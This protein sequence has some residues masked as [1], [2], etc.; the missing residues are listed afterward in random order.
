MSRRPRAGCTPRERVVET[1]VTEAARQLR[2]AGLETPLLAVVG[3]VVT[4]RAWLGAS[5]PH[6]HGASCAPGAGARGDARASG[7]GERG[8]SL[9]ISVA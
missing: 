4:L 1:T 8:V 9:G 7:G 5:A 2:E 6:L 3:W